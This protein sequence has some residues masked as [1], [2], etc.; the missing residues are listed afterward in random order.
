MEMVPLTRSLQYTLLPIKYINKHSST[1]HGILPSH[2]SSSIIAPHLS[3]VVLHSTFGLKFDSL[4]LLD[5]TYN[6]TIVTDLYYQSPLR[7]EQTRNL[8]TAEH[9]RHQL[10]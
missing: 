1:D 7:Y 4:I 9:F 10:N 8:A 5:N 2:H 6:L 3:L